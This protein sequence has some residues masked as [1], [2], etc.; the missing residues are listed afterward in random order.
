M[1]YTA[2][3][4]WLLVIG[5]NKPNLIKNTYRWSQKSQQYLFQIFRK[6]NSACFTPKC[7]IL[8]RSKNLAGN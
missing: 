8:I 2:Y 1:P 5:R 7:K 6:L 3:E 4:V